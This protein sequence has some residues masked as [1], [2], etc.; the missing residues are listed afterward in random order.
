MGKFGTVHTFLHTH[1]VINLLP[2]VFWFVFCLLPAIPPA[3]VLNQKFLMLLE[4]FLPIWV[5]Y[6]LPFAVALLKYNTDY[7]CIP[8]KQMF[9]WGNGGLLCV[10]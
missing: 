5:V 10:Y 9:W 3:S 2:L 7:S 8:K 4:I 6:V 1:R